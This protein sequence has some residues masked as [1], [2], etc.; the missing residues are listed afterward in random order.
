MTEETAQQSAGEQSTLPS[1]VRCPH[2]SGLL[3]TQLGKGKV[4]L[5]APRPASLQR[6]IHRT[7]RASSLTPDQSREF[8]LW[9]EALAPRL[10]WQRLA[11][12]LGVTKTT[13]WNWRRRRYTPPPKMWAKYRQIVSD[14]FNTQHRERIARLYTN[15]APAKRDHRAHG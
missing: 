8:Y 10:P 1:L 5:V 9:L 15:P 14:H 12:L 2:C 3:D 4:P 11:Y 13:V 6:G 7:P